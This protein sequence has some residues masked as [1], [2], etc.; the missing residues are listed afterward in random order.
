MIPSL[1]ELESKSLKALADAAVRGDLDKPSVLNVQSF[2]HTGLVQQVANELKQ[3][4]SEGLTRPGLVML[5]ET[6]VAERDRQE[7]HGL[8]ANLVWSGPDLDG[9]HSR[10]TRVVVHELFRK[11][12]KQVLVSTY[13]LYQG[14]ELFQPLYETQAAHPDLKVTLFVDIARGDKTNST[15]QLL[16]EFRAKFNEDWPWKPAPEVYYDP[17]SLAEAG[18]GKRGCLHAKVVVVDGREVFLTSANLTEAAQQRNIEAGLLLRSPAIATQLANHFEAL[19]KE[20]HLVRLA[21]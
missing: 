9:D 17:R 2:V 10:D 19:V 1:L 3:A 8:R 13:K 12:R 18:T 5:L 16:D 6:L 14:K 20:G 15:Q 7:R 11:A 21:T 4:M